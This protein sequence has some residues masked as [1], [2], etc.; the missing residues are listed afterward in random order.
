MFKD[1]DPVMTKTKSQYAS[2]ESWLIGKTIEMNISGSAPG[3][4]W[5]E[6][7]RAGFRTVVTDAGNMSGGPVFYIHTA[8][9]IHWASDQYRDWRIIPDEEL[10]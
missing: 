1:F 10:H 9:G 2:V 8:A 3:A 4:A 6:T 5:D 7:R